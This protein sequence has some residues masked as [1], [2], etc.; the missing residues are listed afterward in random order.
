MIPIKYSQWHLAHHEYLVHHEFVSLLLILR[1]SSAGLKVIAVELKTCLVDRQPRS[2][3]GEPCARLPSELMA[4]LGPSALS[5]STFPVILRAGVQVAFEMYFSS[6]A[7]AGRG[8][9]V[10]RR[11]QGPF[12]GAGGRGGVGRS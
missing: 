2:R 5:P 1:D 9:T 12:E 7:W 11:S 6:P 8:G 3:A 10:G 4:G